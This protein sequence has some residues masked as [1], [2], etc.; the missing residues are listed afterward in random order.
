MRSY[1]DYLREQ[2]KKRAR[3]NRKRANRA[4]RPAVYKRDAK[5][6]VA[7]GSYAAYLQRTGQLNGPT[8]TTNTRGLP[9]GVSWQQAA[10]D[11]FLGRVPGAITQATL[12]QAALRQQAVYNKSGINIDRLNLNLLDRGGD[13]QLGAFFSGIGGWTG[14][15]SLTFAGKL[16]ETA[17]RFGAP[18]G[19]LF[20]GQG[21]KKVLSSLGAPLNP[22]FGVG[23]EQ[24]TPP[25]EGLRSAG[26]SDAFQWSTAL[27]LPQVG[28]PLN[29]TRLLPGRVGKQTNRALTDVAADIAFNPLSLLGGGLGSATARVTSIRSAKYL[30]AIRRMNQGRRVPRGVDIPSQAVTP[31]KQVANRYRIAGQRAV[32]PRRGPDIRVAP[33]RVVGRPIEDAPYPISGRGRTEGPGRSID[34]LAPKP[35]GSAAGGDWPNVVNPVTDALRQR[36]RLAAGIRAQDDFTPGASIQA[37]SAAALEARVAAK[38]T[39]DATR[40]PTR[41]VASGKKWGRSEFRLRDSISVAAR[42]ASEQPRPVPQVRGLPRIRA[43]SA[44]GSGPDVPIRSTKRVQYED[45]FAPRPR[46]AYVPVVSTP[47]RA[48]RRPY[49]YEPRSKLLR[50]DSPELA[51]RQIR[52]KRGVEY[53][54]GAYRTRKAADGSWEVVNKWRKPVRSLGRHA[55][56]SDAITAARAHQIGRSEKAFHASRRIGKPTPEVSVGGPRKGLTPRDIKRSEDAWWSPDYQR[57]QAAERARK[58]AQSKEQFIA[59]MVESHRR[60]K[61][62]VHDGSDF[63]HLTTRD[64]LGAR[65]AGLGQHGVASLK[66]AIH[67]RIAQLTE[68]R[69]IQNNSIGSAG[70]QVEQTRNMRGFTIRS[71]EAAKKL[72]QLEARQ[73]R[74]IQARDA[75]QAA[76]DQLHRKS[77]LID[78]FGLENPLPPQASSGVPWTVKNVQQATAR[79]LELQ[80]SE[81]S[82]LTQIKDQLKAAREQRRLRE[83]QAGKGLEPTQHQQSMMQPRGEPKFQAPARISG[84]APSG[85]INVTVTGKVVPRDQARNPYPPQQVEATSKAMVQA[86][87]DALA[88][89]A[90]PTAKRVLQ[91]NE[92]ARRAATAYEKA[93]VR[94]HDDM[95]KIAQK[96]IGDLDKLK[97]SDRAKRGQRIASEYFHTNM[98]KELGELALK[99]RQLWEKLGLDTDIPIGVRI[100]LPYTYHGANPWVVRGRE[101]SGFNIPLFPGKFRGKVS[102]KLNAF[103]E[104]KFG[105]SLPKLTAWWRMM[106]V[107]QY[108]PNRA[109]GEMLANLDGSF[110]HKQGAA[111]RL[112]R[113]ETDQAMRGLDKA[114]QLE[115]Q[116]IASHWLEGTISRYAVITGGPSITG[117]SKNLIKNPRGYLRE[118]NRGGDSQA[119]GEGDLLQRMPRLVRAANGPDDAL[120]PGERIV[121]IRQETQDWAELMQAMVAGHTN[122]YAR[123]MNLMPGEAFE[124]IRTSYVAHLMRKSVGDNA[125]I[126]AP[127]FTQDSI[128]FGNK[129]GF[130]QARKKGVGDSLHRMRE[131]GYDVED[132]LAMIVMRRISANNRAVQDGVI[133][134][135]VQQHY[136]VNLSGGVATLTRDQVRLLLGKKGKR[137]SDEQ[138]DSWIKMARNR[139]EDPEDAVTQDELIEA[140]Q[141]QPLADI[142]REGGKKNPFLS[143][144]RLD[145]NTYVPTDVARTLSNHMAIRMR[146]SEGF[147]KGAQQANSW[148]KQWAL[149]TTGYDMRNQYGDMWLV[150]ESGL[151]PIK[152]LI[153]GVQLERANI[154]LHRGKPLGG[155]NRTRTSVPSILGRGADKHKYN[156]TELGLLSQQ[157]GVGDIGLLAAETG[158]LKAT[159][160][161]DVRVRGK[162]GKAIRSIRGIRVK[163]E[164]LNRRGTFAH[165]VQQGEHPYLA[166]KQANRTLFNYKDIGRFVEHMRSTPLY[167]APFI[168]WPAKNIPYQAKNWWTTPNRALYSGMRE[169]NQAATSEDGVYPDAASQPNYVTEGFGIPANFGNLPGPLGRLGQSFFRFQPPVADGLDMLPLGIFGPGSR[170]NIAGAT[171]F[172]RL[173]DK[174]GLYAGVAGPFPSTVA[175]VLSGQ[176]LQTGS[177]LNSRVPATGAES[178]IQRILPGALGGGEQYTTT[179]GPDGEEIAVPSISGAKRLLFQ[180]LFPPFGTVSRAGGVNKTGRPEVGGVDLRSALSSIGGIGTTSYNDPRGQIGA[181]GGNKRE[182]NEQKGKLNK[183][184]NAWASRGWNPD[185]LQVQD[186]GGGIYVIIGGF[187][188]SEVGMVNRYNEAATRYASVAAATDRVFA[189]Q[190]G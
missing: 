156:S 57:L 61:P 88:G 163:R 106:F 116:M 152:T 183:V 16:L 28:V 99:S 51:G 157:Y 64:M 130:A 139:T 60:T 19:A 24:Y 48:G 95:E 153:R 119:A 176:N 171:R 154:R 124:R 58:E 10:T 107:S 49:S 105:V 101:V 155:V 115:Q 136:G 42:R 125:D 65:L 159:R 54:V 188:P 43:A 169:A 5:P 62:V 39:L 108:G 26:L 179:T 151:N 34:Q 121:E 84:G 91:T 41:L 187:P 15:N 25:S 7:P 22:L 145:E 86:R 129:V 117:K 9:R 35:S 150:A 178:I 52:T 12:A 68:T 29:A 53:E 186:V 173:K 32:D 141:G 137:W 126:V 21:P 4:G 161:G 180:S 140:L 1:A 70:K 67:K 38:A 127:R 112:I 55:K 90:T 170:N 165:L 185:D 147:A 50:K 102:P 87:V 120:A 92:A 160:Y 36:A 2:D 77:G 46:E 111:Q 72:E 63:E 97:R 13:S 59:G 143:T 123:M 132:N 66:R 118:A 69:S 100:W 166:A 174:L 47:T 11:N 17:D 181:F 85:D 96:R 142:L 103:V 146:Y 189:E 144:F 162:F 3:N 131:E 167:G 134:Q 98:D 76:I 168:T 110:T 20:S 75:T 122:E 45:A 89:A 135:L 83:L 74:L 114:E 133:G 138:I 71:E 93:V 177:D 148:W 82:V 30:D 27:A 79:R 56:A 18:A 80:A 172:D 73:A 31:S 164:N 104:S 37:K 184:L 94:I 128:L 14:R 6:R 113:R 149:A 190:G 8:G 175:S 44:R 78:R 182:F 33:P 158:S 109:V 40:T 23:P 81:K